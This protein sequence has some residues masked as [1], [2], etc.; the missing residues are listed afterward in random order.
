MGAVLHHFDDTAEVAFCIAHC[1]IN[2]I[3]EEAGFVDPELSFVLFSTAEFVD[4]FAHH[5]SALARMAI[6]HLT[7]N[8]VFAAWEDAVVG[9]GIETNEFVFIYKTDVEGQ[10][11]IDEIDLLQGEFTSGDIEFFASSS[12]I[13]VFRE[14]LL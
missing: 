10:M 4:D 5:V 12:R 2:D 7:T 9:V 11:L 13:A 8:D 3:D 1:H 14:K 6:H